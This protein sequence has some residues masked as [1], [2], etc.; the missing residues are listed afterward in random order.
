M[1]AIS[2]THNKAKKYND[3]VTMANRCLLL[4]KRNPDTILTSIVLPVMMML[5]F[6]SLF[7]SLVAVGDTSY[8]NY[9]VPGV[10]LQCFGQCS[11]VTAIAVN[12]DITS[13]IMNRFCTLP[14]RKSS[15]LSGHIVEAM[16]R[17]TL[18][19]S[20]VLLA[21]FLLGFRPAASLAGWCMV[22]LLLAG[23]IL[24][25]SWLSA[26][27]GILAN[28]AEGASGI[29]TMVIV[30]PYL[31]SGFVPIEAMPKALAV[32]AKYQPMTPIIDT[33]R[34]ALLG[35]PLE[36]GTLLAAF[37]WCIGAVT[38]SYF[39]AMALFKKRLGK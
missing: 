7:G 8:V 17:N 24:A 30:L 39:L 12:R 10:L 34:N 11:S 22:A 32:F 35:K 1:E 2:K 19:A 29:F 20:V 6:V 14:I 3:T 31:S 4:S 26:V 5:L 15:I 18:T 36:M 13:G 16:V 25:F 23:V 37:L 28:S 27:V 38:I 33:M 9:I 21:A